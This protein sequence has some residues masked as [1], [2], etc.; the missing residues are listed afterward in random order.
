MPTA[1]MGSR[2][3]AYHA[4][5]QALNYCVD[6]VRCTVSCPVYLHVTMVY[7]R[8]TIVYLRVTNGI[9]L[10]RQ[11]DAERYMCNLL[12]PQESRAGLF[13][14][15]AFNIETAKVRSTI[16]DANIGRMRL[17]WWRETIAQSLEGK[18]PEHPVAQA[19]AQAHAQFALT[20]R[21]FEQM[22]DARESDL[23]STQPE[24]WGQALPPP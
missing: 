20:P 17:L 18:P 19:L 10:S 23:T 9:D 11:H 13:A 22:I 15:H 12:A 5:T 1:R 21:Y 14:I 3:R 4:P 24:T 8:V 6:F 2:L 16:K 7:L